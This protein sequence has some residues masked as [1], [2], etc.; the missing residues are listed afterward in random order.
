[1]PR[2]LLGTQCFVDIAAGSGLPPQRWISALDPIK[3]P[4]RD[5]TISAVTPMILTAS[6][7]G[8][9]TPSQAALRQSCEQ[10]VQRFVLSKRVVPITKEI[11]DRWGQ[12]LTFSLAFERG[13]ASV[14]YDYR[15]RLVMATAIEGHDGIPFTLVE[16][17][18][19]AHT[20]LEPI[21]L[22][23]ADPYVLH[24]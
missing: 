9:L 22:V 4:A 16:R 17:R 11:A 21:G 12:L 2:Y 13:G 3:V 23:L 24:P 5:V 18:Q 8:Q 14:D 19:P 6:F 1:M 20:A 15:E 10:L 7:A